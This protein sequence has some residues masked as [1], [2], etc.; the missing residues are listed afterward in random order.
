MFLSHEPANVL[1]LL[2]HMRTQVNTPSDPDLLPRG[3]NKSTVWIMGLLV[4]TVVTDFA[5]HC[6]SPCFSSHVSVLLL[7]HLPPLQ[8][9]TNQGANSMLIKPLADCLGHIVE[10]EGHVRL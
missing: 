2:S 1:F 3:L 10:E 6:L 8:P 7:W 5:N 9:D 4:E